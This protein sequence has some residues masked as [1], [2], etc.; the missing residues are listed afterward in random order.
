MRGISRRMGG[1]AMAGLAAAACSAWANAGA[2]AEAST[3]RAVRPLLLYV[4]DYGG[5]AVTPINTATGKAGSP[6]KVGRSPDQ[7]AITPDG[8]TVYVADTGGRDVTPI[9]TATRKP[10]QPIQVGARPVGIVAAPNGKAV[11]VLA[12]GLMVPISTA[13]GKQG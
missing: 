10:G 8:K 5:R 13:S 3:G 7:L 2:A 6:I 9:S 4:T 1:M 11:Y 12:T